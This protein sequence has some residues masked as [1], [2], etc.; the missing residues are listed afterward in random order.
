MNIRTEAVESEVLD[1]SQAYP[2][3]MAFDRRN[4]LLGTEFSRSRSQ[5]E[6]RLHG[7]TYTPQDLVEGIVS[8]AKSLCP[9]PKRIIDAGA[10][11]GRFTMSV[12]EVFP[13]AEVIAV[14][15]DPEAAEVLCKNLKLAGLQNRV[16]VEVTDYRTLELPLIDG[17]TLFIG[18]PP[19][20]RHHDI[21]D[22]WKAWL[23]VEAEK[24]GLKASQLSGLHVHFFLQTLR[25]SSAGDVCLFVTA[26]EWM[27]TNYGSFLRSCLAGPLGGVSVHVAPP[28]TVVF[29]DAMTT[30]AITACRPR[31]KQR[32]INFA[33]PTADWQ[34][35]EGSAIETS[36]LD[37]SRSWTPRL[38]GDSTLESGEDLVS[39]GDFFR[40][41]RGQVT[42]CNKA[43]VVGADT[44][45]LPESCLVKTVTKAKQITETGHI[46]ECIDH[47]KDVVEL[48][49]DLDCLPAKDR[50][51]VDAFLEWA[52]ARGAHT[53]YIAKH[54]TPWWRVGLQVPAPILCTYMG[55][56]P[57]VFVLNPKGAPTLNVV[58][59]LWPRKAMTSD[60]LERVCIWLRENV[61]IGQGRTYAGGL[62]K[63]EPK[64]VE[65]IQVP[66]VIFGEK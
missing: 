62:T 6:R 13:D 19:Y 54:R 26:A 24:F 44:P 45:E 21:S 27:D 47:L 11:S 3:S 31:T 56:R 42:G 8:Y 2:G 38:N 7:A 18:N 12:A 4:D 34:F 64:E 61:T 33:R 51:K 36:D 55:R 43:F 53:S 10:G 39:L 65:R 25:L 5:R 32:T 20:I 52:C 50:Q 48:P 35:I 63:F 9:N 37:A 58:H 66:K 28:E 22:S 17:P 29:E 41:S 46:L 59:G 30:A 23:Q 1:L 16:K 57:P 14:E 40:V 60:T 15:Y 49:H